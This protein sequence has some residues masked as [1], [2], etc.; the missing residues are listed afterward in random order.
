MTTSTLITDYLGR[1]T[2]A[3]RPASVN[4]PSGGIAVYYA[5]DTGD[6]SVWNG[7]AW[8]GFGALGID[9]QGTQAV[10]TATATITPATGTTSVVV[11]VSHN[12]TLTIGNGTYAGQHLRLE[13]LQDATGSRTIAFDSSVE[14]GTDVTS[15][16]ATTTANKRD[17]VQL[18]WQ[19]TIGAWMFAAVNHGFA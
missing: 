3:S 14:F 10:S 11:T 2:A 17:L 4:V 19:A 18:Y 6:F 8:V 5:T 13:L 12:T 16:T 1:G 7:S 9:T 15:F